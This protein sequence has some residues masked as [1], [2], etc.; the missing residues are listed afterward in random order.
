[1]VKPVIIYPN[2]LLKQVCESVSAADDIGGI[3][4]DL[5]DTM[6]GSG[7]SVGIAAPQIGVLRRIVLINASL[8][9]KPCENHGEVALINPE[10][11]DYD[12]FIRTREGCM[13]VPEFTGD[14]NRA[15]SVTVSYLD[16]NLSPKTMTAD[17]FEAIVLQHEI[18]HLDGILFVD[19]VISRKR[20]LYRRKR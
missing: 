2:P 11:T 16:E 10:I 3:I 15:Q 8:G 7:H 17:G 14:V 4:G 9:R 13:S 12:G 6:V 18:D 19:R 20:D 1:M 5:R